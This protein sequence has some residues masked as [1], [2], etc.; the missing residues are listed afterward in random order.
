MGAFRR[1]AKTLRR[2]ARRMGKAASSAALF[3]VFLIFCGCIKVGP[4]YKVPVSNTPAQWHMTGDPTFTSDKMCSCDWWTVFDDPLLSRLVVEAKACNLE[5]KTAVARIKEARAKVGIAG[6]PFFPVLDSTGYLS[7]ERNSANSTS[8]FGTDTRFNAGLNSSWEV[9]LFGRISRSVEAAR[10]DYQVSEEDYAYV[11]VSLY[12]EVARTYLDV[13]TVQAR[14]GA[15]EGNIASQQ[16]V[17]ELT[18]KRFSFGLATNLDVSQAENILATSEAQLPP[19]RELLTRSMNAVALL[20]GKPPG[21]FDDELGRPVPIPLPPPQAAVGIPADLVRRRPDIREAERRLA[22]ETA[23]IGVATSDLYPRLTLLGTLGFESTDAASWMSRG[24]VFYSLA[25]TLQWNIFHG[26]RILSQIAVQD[27]LTEQALL[28]YQQ[29]VLK[30]LGEVENEMKA[31]VEA[32]NRK[33]AL[34]RSVAASRRTLDLAI[35]LYKD[36][37]KDFQNVLDAERTLFD[38]ENQLA[39]AKG[40]IAV[41]LVQL[42]KA[43]GGG[44]GPDGQAPSGGLQGAGDPLKSKE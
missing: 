15:T 19:L 14:L 29:I 28:Q 7:R 16:K 1:Q 38:S 36:G 10:A 39:V 9:D 27:A 5:L 4:D 22:A 24:S 11:M 40:E 44:W 32:R 3:S 12:A 37:L 25:P 17:L 42:Y 20:L 26:G 43:L 8:F 21:F 34:E 41:A 13:R 2:R 33:E 35:H 18:Q 23:R 31:F 30:A 6:S